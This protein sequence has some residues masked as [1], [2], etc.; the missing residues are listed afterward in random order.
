MKFPPFKPTLLL[1]C[2]AMI[3]LLIVSC[4]KEDQ[5]NVD[6]E[7]KGITPATDINLA[8]EK[9]TILS[10]DDPDYFIGEIPP[11]TVEVIPP[12]PFNG[13]ETTTESS[14]TPAVVDISTQA[15]VPFS[16]NKTATLSLPSIGDIMVHFD[17]SG[18]MSGELNNVKANAINIFNDINVEITDLQAGV[19]SGLEGYT[20]NQDL[21]SSGSAFSSAVNAISLTGGVFEDYAEHFYRSADDPSWRTN[22]AR[23]ALV[24]LDERPQE[25]SP[26]SMTQGLAKIAA[27]EVN[28][29]V[30]YSGPSNSEFNQWQSLAAA[31]DFNVFRLNTNGTIPG[32]LSISDFIIDA[33]EDA[34]C[35]V[36]KVELKAVDA[37]YQSWIS[38]VNPTEYTNVDVCVD[39]EMSFEIT[40]EVPNC[41][42]PDFYSFEVGL[43]GDDILYATQT[44]NVT[45]EACGVGLDVHPGSCPNP[46]NTNSNGITP[47]AILGSADFDVHDIDLSQITLNGVAP[48]AWHKYDD[49]GTP[50]MPLLG[51]PTD[52]YACNTDGADGYVDLK[53]KF[54]TADLIATLPSPEGGDVFVLDLDAVLNNGKCIDGE[55]VIKI[56]N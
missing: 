14:L 33:I 12:L 8:T 50:E 13:P 56:S 5:V 1:P 54:K 3:I 48:K 45:L 34:F 17:L 35:D 25:Y 52:P 16:E 15:G 11:A 29:I 21:T 43:Y 23:V 41:T 9:T 51:K 46:L 6:N 49:V 18:S 36:A 19:S 2:L 22:A 40:Y 26:Y 53:L 38:S 4:G 47:V 42:A 10:P 27:E 32:G 20:L 37:N 28:L 30:F 7:V 55:D 24:F 39:P 31:N 44:V